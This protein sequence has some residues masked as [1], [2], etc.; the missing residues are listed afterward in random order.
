MICALVLVLLAAGGGDAPPALGPNLLLNA[1]FADGLAGWSLTGNGWSI[2]PTGG[3]D[4]GPCLRHDPTPRQGEPSALQGVAV[5]LAAPYAVRARVRWEGA[6]PGD[7]APVVFASVRPRT[8]SEWGGNG[9]HPDA[10]PG[11]QDV[12]SSVQVGGP[13]PPY[14][15]GV[16]ICPS[17]TGTLWVD[18]V[19][20]YLSDTEL[21]FRP[22][23]ASPRY[24]GLILPGD[25][26]R[27]ELALPVVANLRHPAPCLGIR[28]RLRDQRGTTVLEEEL[29]AVGVSPPPSR[30]IDVSA[31][32]PGDYSCS[33]ALEDTRTG[34]RLDNAL[35]PFAIAPPSELGPRARLD[36]DGRW[37]SHGAPRF[38]VVC[39]TSARSGAELRRIRDA[40]F[41]LVANAA[42]F[43][44]AAEQAREWL[45][46]VA[47][48]DM[49]ALLGLGRDGYWEPSAGDGLEA[50]V[51]LARALADHRALTGWVLCAYPWG[52]A[53]AALAGADR[54]LRA[55]SHDLPVVAGS[56]PWLDQ[57]PF[58]LA[59][60]LA[61]APSHLWSGDDLFE[62][63]G[64]IDRVFMETMLAGR[65][66]LGAWVYL[67]ALPPPGWGPAVPPPE[68]A[69]YRFHALWAVARGARGLMVD[70]NVDGEPG[71]P[72]GY[73]EALRGLTS[74]LEG[75]APFLT[76]L[77]VDAEEAV[78]CE[79]SR[80]VLSTRRLPDCRQAL[81]TWAYGAGAV[82]FRV[83][84][85][86]GDVWA[87]LPGEEP[88]RIPVVG[89][90][91]ED[92]LSGYG[93][94][95]YTIRGES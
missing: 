45:D 54:E 13:D 18:R 61:L 17:E 95:L 32:A 46:A 39:H 9:T 33:V 31:L 91:F 38:P 74:L 62:G 64:R 49:S 89:G 71:A 19:E 26:R 60:D 11:W 52:Y 94:R 42:P 10:T 66:P 25:P 16:R 86:E 29:T 30:T 57:G 77:E 15:A 82:R 23:L 3:E 35:L 84:A 24:R 7:R 47:A 87:G 50:A 83:R 37:I 21:T 67:D 59:G 80:V 4:G 90:C 72:A 14:H 70:W 81:V 43:G 69:E 28:I 8:S 65:L 63:H 34:E 55:V 56:T 92:E 6:T 51:A 20:L 41:T 76:A 22:A 12:V 27:L 36:A 75:I 73:S 48:H 85:P 53:D 78:S 68:E 79:D 5:D 2:D 44:A 1:G 88:R 58:G 93:A 40:G